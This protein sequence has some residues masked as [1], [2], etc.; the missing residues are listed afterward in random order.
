MTY[1]SPWSIRAFLYNAFEIATP[2]LDEIFIQVVQGGNHGNGKKELQHE[3]D[4]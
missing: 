2:S 1:S 4:A 3:Q